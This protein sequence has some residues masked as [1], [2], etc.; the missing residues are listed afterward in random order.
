MGKYSLIALD[1]DGT[2]LNSELKVSE[3]N[4]DAVRRAAQAGKHVVIST[5]RCL[6]ELRHVV[7]ELPEIR[8]L[9]CENGSCVYDMKYDHTIHV[10]PVPT[11][12]VVDI[13]ELLRGER[14]V[15]QVFHENQSYFNAKDVD[16]ADAC[17]VGNYR[18][19]FR[20]FS[21]FDPK[22]FAGYAA[23]PF[24]IEKINLYFEN[25][26]DRERIRE[27]LEGRPLKLADSIG[28]ML[29][30]VS[31]L[32]DKGRGLRKLCAHLG[33]PMEETIAMGDQMNDVEI[34]RAAGFSAAMGNACPDAKAAATIVAPDCDHDGVA[35]VIDRYLIGEA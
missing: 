29:E 26:S 21:A 7:R 19:L 30:V 11:Q 34:L 16:W 6:S 33:V 23:R 27:R 20:S 22:L 15:I 2:L 1:M 35:W 4:R 31:S 14:T 28:Y 8:Y 9:V 10:D 24:R 18:E 5:G 25:V 13:L 3:G 17:R 32:A 12:E